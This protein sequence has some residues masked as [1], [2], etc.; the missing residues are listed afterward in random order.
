MGRKRKAAKHDVYSDD[1]GSDEG[2]AKVDVRLDRVESYEYKAPEN[3]D[4][5]DD[6]EIEESDAF[7]SEDEDIY[8]DHTFIKSDPVFGCL[9]I[10][11]LLLHLLFALSAT[12]LDENSACQTLR[13]SWMKPAAMNRTMTTAS[14][15]IPK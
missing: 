14:W 4:P 2:G 15:M 11:T 7:N 6:E 9:L 1:E 8:A 5:D 10:L 12:R 13:I 3:I